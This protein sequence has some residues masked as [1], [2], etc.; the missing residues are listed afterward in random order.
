MKSKTVERLLNSIPEDV[1][2]FTDLYADLL[3]RIHQLLQEK[4]ISKK[5]LAEKL[6]K[7]PSEIS[8]WLNNEHNFTLQSIAK[9]SAELGEPLLEVP[10]KKMEQQLV[11]GFIRSEH[12]FVVYRKVE[13]LKEKT[14]V[15]E[16][17]WEATSELNLWSDAG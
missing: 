17:E 11:E 2:I 6:G 15:K 7:N 12:H 1:K 8:K 5:E 9:L 3:V 13:P 4:G 10:K 16:I 14:K